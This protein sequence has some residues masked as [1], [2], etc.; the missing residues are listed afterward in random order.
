[1]PGT[2]PSPLGI[3]TLRLISEVE[4][5]LSMG[6]ALEAG[7]RGGGRKEGEE[8]RLRWEEI[9]PRRSDSNA[10]AITYQPA[11]TVVSKVCFHP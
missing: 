4:C 9:M 2:A 5:V 8:M 10:D 7:K 3:L 6:E 11:L 1:M